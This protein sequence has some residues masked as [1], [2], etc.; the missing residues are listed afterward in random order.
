[1]QIARAE[2]APLRMPEADNV[3]AKRKQRRATRRISMRQAE[4]I[5]D[6]VP[7]AKSICLPLVAHITIHWGYTD[8]GDDPEGRRFAKFREGLDKWLGRKDIEFAAVWARER[9]SRGQAEVEHCHLLFHLPEGYRTGN[10]LRETEVAIYRLIK[11]HGSR[12]GDKNGDGYWADEVVKVVIHANHAGKYLIKGGGP[13]IWKRFRLRKEHRRWQG[14]IHGKRCGTT[15][16][17]GKASRKRR[18]S[19]TGM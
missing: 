16:N 2:T 4:N 19:K 11:R 5:M 10:G 12:D 1:M 9:M 15:E 17:I 13:P 3:T 7:F 8:V 6:A 18:A 14:L